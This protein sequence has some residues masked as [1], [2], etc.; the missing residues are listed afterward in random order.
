MADWTGAQWV[1]IFHDQ[2]VEL[3]GLTADE[4]IARQESGGNS[5]DCFVN[6]N[7][8]EFLFRLRAKVENYNVSIHTINLLIQ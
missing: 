2:A 3:F 4:V 8:H 1:N 7:F 6:T 5:T